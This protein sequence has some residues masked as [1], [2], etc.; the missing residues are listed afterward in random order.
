MAALN[1]QIAGTLIRFRKRH[2]TSCRTRTSACRSHMS[3]CLRSHRMKGGGPGWMLPGRVVYP[4]MPG[5]RVGLQPEQATRRSKKALL[6]K[7][8]RRSEP[9]GMRSYF[10]L[11][12]ML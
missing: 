4:G 3:C 5:Q 8:F 1:G 2:S 11:P 7:N 12:D 10:Y 6:G 9:G